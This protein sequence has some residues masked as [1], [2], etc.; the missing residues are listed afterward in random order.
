MKRVFA[1]VII[2]LTFT[3]T[4]SAQKLADLER[5]EPSFWWVGFKNHQLQLIVHGNEISQREVQIDYSGV[6]L[7]SV[8]K[9]ENPNYMFL[10]LLISDDA[11]PGKFDII[12]SLKGKKN[13]IYSYQLKA[14]NKGTLAQGVTDKDLIYLIMP[15]RFANGNYSNDKISGL[16]DQTFSRDSMYYRHGGDIQGIIDHLDYLKDL[17]ATAL[18]LTPVQENDEFKTSYHGYANTENYKIDPRYGTNELYKKLVEDAHQKE[19]KIVMDVV[20]NHV[21]S[22]HWTVLDKPFKDWVHQWPSFTRTTYKDQT[23]FDPH[24]SAADKKLMQNG[25]FDYHMPDMNQ[26][27]QMVANYIEQ[28]YIFWIEY[29]GVDGFRIDTYPYNN[30]EFMAHWQKRVKDEY[31]NFTLYGET[32]VHGMANQAYF[33]QGKT[34]NQKIDTE[35][36]ATTDFQVHF[37][38][39]DALNQKF[40][41]TEGVNELYTVLASDYLY[42]DAYRNVIFLDN[43]DITRFYSGV[44]EDFTKF[45]S[46]L[47]MLLTLRGV[48]QIYYGTELAMPGVNNPDG[49]LRADFLGGWKADQTNKFTSSGRTSK[50][51]EAFNYIKTLANYRKNTPALQTGKMMQYVPVDGIYVYFR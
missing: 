37:S 15:D 41:W 39:L 38:L 4:I 10:N 5:V 12:F 51:N 8:E 32:Y 43:H 45:K 20:P 49:L 47:A 23:L 48:P 16:K 2:F 21:G 36:P 29:A 24:A 44:G 3:Q 18:W 42:Q 22:Q 50:E 33:T 40:G 31:P 13:L 46:G 19:M 14:R 30:L 28:S 26:E 35:L 25:W 17:G 34:V 9:V 1:I 27:N 6:S 11:Q 7:K